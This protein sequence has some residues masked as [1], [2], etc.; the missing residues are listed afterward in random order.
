MKRLFGGC[1]DKKKAYYAS[2]EVRIK[3]NKIRKLRKH[4]KHHPNDLQS[5]KYLS[6]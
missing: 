2:G 4:I 3:A 1:S 5:A 6:L